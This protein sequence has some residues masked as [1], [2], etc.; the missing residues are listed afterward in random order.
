MPSPT[1]LTSSFSVIALRKL[2]PRVSLRDFPPELLLYIFRF[3]HGDPGR[4]KSL[5]SATHVC[6][7]WRALAISTSM[8][9]T[10]FRLEDTSLATTYLERS[11]AGPL[12]VTLH[13]EANSRAPLH[14]ICDIVRPHI[15]RIVDLDAYVANCDD[16]V[17]FAHETQ[18]PAPALKRL[19]LS[20]G[21][22]FKVECPP[23]FSG[24][25]NPRSLILQN[26]HSFIL[27]APTSIS[28]LQIYDGLPPLHTLL[29]VL[30]YC[31]MLT[32]LTINSLS[33]S[34]VSSDKLTKLHVELPRLQ[35][36]MLAFH[37]VTGG[38]DTFLSHLTIPD[39]AKISILLYVAYGNDLRLAPLSPLVFPRAQDVRGIHLR[40][41]R[42]DQLDI[43]TYKNLE[44]RERTSNITVI[45]TNEGFDF[46]IAPCW[47]IDVSKVDVLNVD[48]QKRATVLK[49]PR[50]LELLQN[51]QILRLSRP[52]SGTVNTLCKALVDMTLAAEDIWEDSDTVVLSDPSP[53]VIPRYFPRLTHVLFIQ[54]AWRKS[55]SKVFQR[56]VDFRERFLDAAEFHLE[57][58]D[59]DGF[60]TRDGMPMETAKYGV[61]ILPTEMAASTP[62]TLELDEGV[63]IRPALPHGDHECW[64]PGGNHHPGSERTLART[65]TTMDESYSR[66]ALPH[67]SQLSEAAVHRTMERGELLRLVQDGVTERQTLMRNVADDITRLQSIQNSMSFVNRLPPELLATIFFFVRTG[68]GRNSDVRLIRMTHVCAQWRAVALGAAGLW[69]RVSLDNTKGIEA[70]LQRSGA[71]PVHLS[72][73]LT[74]HPV[75]ATLRLIGSNMDRIRSLKVSVPGN[76][77]TEFV[78]NRLK[79]FPAPM[80]EEMSIEKTL[81]RV[82]YRHFLRRWESDVAETQGTPALR[83]LKLNCVPMFFIPKGPNALTTIILSGFKIPS[84]PNLLKLL[85]HSP[86]LEHL[87]INGPFTG[88]PLDPGLFSSAKLLHLKTF[89]LMIR[90]LLGVAGLLSCLQLAEQTDITI[91]T[92]SYHGEGFAQIFPAEGHPLAFATLA[93]RRLELS[94][95]LWKLNL[96]AYRGADDFH[97][98]ALQVVAA[99][100][101]PRAGRSFLGDWAFDTSRVETLVVHGKREV[102]ARRWP[103]VFAALPALKTLRLMSIGV[104]NMEEITEAFVAA[105]QPLCPELETVEVFD[106]GSHAESSAAKMFMSR[107]LSAAGIHPK[108]VELFNMQCWILG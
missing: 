90:P 31:P 26:F 73:S 34:E 33:W 87:S 91:T 74:H 96:R 4:N 11:R 66:F 32:Q 40:W 47:P 71:L 17:A 29:A 76:L 61:Q 1:G 81:I 102:E 9:W 2:R 104:S 51:L 50:G 107:G 41:T 106:L 23:L 45:H 12:I 24:V 54:F 52:T 101:A 68:S 70:F 59:V 88:D 94:W 46:P 20:T 57:L 39:S 58:F 65:A 100:H 78:T 82:P 35:Q 53:K 44:K 75:K 93:P 18:V 28:D 37:P 7:R 30:G 15:H 99:D 62:G 60:V 77:D 105:R 6:R 27:H 103:A 25:F 13:L 98:P 108:R 19:S 10:R 56:V 22:L 3:L 80:L 5:V 84:L 63:F 83:T 72:V 14:E 16:M 92:S 8:F 42:S 95:D 85:N 48:F 64:Q 67:L 69:K 49:D 97:S 79:A 38:I 21:Y 43:L 89:Q 36:A 86:L 55:F